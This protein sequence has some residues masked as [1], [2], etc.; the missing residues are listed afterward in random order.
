M[1]VEIDA[2][3]FFILNAQSINKLQNSIL[4]REDAD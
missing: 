1:V 3:N 2:A 4:I